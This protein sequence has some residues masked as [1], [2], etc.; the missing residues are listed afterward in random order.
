M[1]AIKDMEMPKSCKECP[2]SYPVFGDGWE[3]WC[4][5]TNKN[6]ATPNHNCP[7]VEIVTCKNCKYNAYQI[8]TLKDEPTR[9]CCQKNR[10]AIYPRIDGF[11]ADGKRRE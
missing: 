10:H 8:S 11:C 9:I 6:V 2:M 7:L 4:S 3:T 1:I 5:F